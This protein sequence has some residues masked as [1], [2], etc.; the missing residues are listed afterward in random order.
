M[1]HSCDGVSWIHVKKKSATNSI[2]SRPLEAL[3]NDDSFE[4]Y[5]FYNKSMFWEFE[6]SLSSLRQRNK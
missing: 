6:K 3:W 4:Y 2:W 1:E 5:K